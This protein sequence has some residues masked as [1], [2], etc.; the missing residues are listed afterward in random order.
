MTSTAPDYGPPPHLDIK[1]GEEPV[2]IKMY[3]GRLNELAEMVGAFERLPEI[4]FNGAVRSKVLEI[5]LAPRGERGRLTDP[6]WSIPPELDIA[7]AKAVLDWVKEHLSD[8]M[9][10]RLEQHLAALQRNSE[11]LTA[12]GS[13]LS[14][15][16][17][18]A[19]K[20]A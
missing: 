1:L 15:L 20:T 11:K 18:S 9:L 2:S 8:F 6:D 12:V 16:A 14:S 17:T 13:S 4:D 7:A 19:S 5:C 3:F 10:G